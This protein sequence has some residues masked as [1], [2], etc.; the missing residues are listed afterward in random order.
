MHDARDPKQV[1]TYLAERGQHHQAGHRRPILRMET[2]TH[3]SPPRKGDRPRR[4]LPSQRYAVDIN[5]LEQR[6]DQVVILRPRA[7]F[8]GDLLQPDPNEPVFKAESRQLRLR[9][10]RALRE[11]LYAFAFV[12]M[13]LAFMGQA[14]TTRTQPHAGRRHSLSPLPIV[15]RVCRHHC[16]QLRGRRTPLR[17]LALCRAGLR[18][19][20]GG[21]HAIQW[22]HLSAAPLEAH[23]QPSLR[24]PNEPVTLAVAASAP[25]RASGASAHRDTAG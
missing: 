5:Q 10:A 4:S 14:Q 11:P 1:V 3:R 18:R 7:R 13:V 20:I 21:N 23:P 17:Y 9:A 19:R 25:R 6:S 24:S 8:T 22:R 12:L 2:R 16:R 15:Y